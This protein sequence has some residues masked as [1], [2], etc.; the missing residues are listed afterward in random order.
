LVRA[1]RFVATNPTGLY[2]SFHVDALISQLTTWD[3][4]A[5]KFDRRRG[6]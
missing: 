6:R 5:E 3:K 2:P 4:I 1:G